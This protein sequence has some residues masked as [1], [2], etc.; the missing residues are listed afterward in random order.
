MKSYAI[1][2]RPPPSSRGETL[3][4]EDESKSSAWDGSPSVSSSTNPVEHN[5]IPIVINDPAALPS[6]YTNQPQIELEENAR[7][8]SQMVTKLRIMTRP[9]NPSNDNDSTNT[10]GNANN[11]M[12]IQEKLK[13]RHE[14]KQAEYLKARLRILGEEM[15]KEELV[16]DGDDTLPAGK[17]TARSGPLL[18]TP[19][20]IQPILRQPKVPD[21]TSGFGK[22]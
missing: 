4:V 11:Q 20:P 7:S 6:F 14:E 22:Q 3:N 9:I 10:N 17:T 1:A 21:G 12:T 5:L 18:P 2:A 8:S 15:P 16:L 13:K 19:S